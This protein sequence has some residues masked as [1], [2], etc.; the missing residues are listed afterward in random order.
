MGATAVAAQALTQQQISKVVKKYTNPI[1]PIT[2]KGHQ[3]FTIN[4]RNEGELKQLQNV[5][6]KYHLDEWTVPQIGK[7]D[8]RVPSEF[9]TG[10]Q[11][12]IQSPISVKIEDLQ[13]AI[14]ESQMVKESGKFTTQLSANPP[15]LEF[16][17]KYRTYEELTQLVKKLNQDYP[18]HTEV[19]SIGKTYEGRDQTGLR[20]KGKNPKYRFVY[21]GGQHAREWI[22]PATATYI[23]NALAGLYGKDDRITKVVDLF[24]IYAIPVL[25]ADG[26][27]YT[28]TKERMWR[29]N[30]QPN[31]GSNCVGT[32]NNRN[33]DAGWGGASNNPCDETYFGSKPF[34]A[35]ETKNIANFIKEKNATAYIDFHSYGQLVMY[36]FGPGCNGNTP[37][38]KKLEE[39]AKQTAKAIDVAPFKPTKMCSAGSKGIGMSIDWATG[40]GKVPYA[41]LIELEGNSFVLP[42]S[43]IIPSGESLLKAVLTMLEY[44]VQH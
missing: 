2:Y 43:K 15:N 13:Q 8:V 20:I 17:K 11:S 42:P 1:R 33:W 14:T 9:I 34:S 18:N 41:F 6:K 44:I 23:L 3:V 32:D 24:D 35:P 4:V 10:V 40:P 12:E 36:T 26:Y 5:I 19:F 38:A 7:V 21:H 27:H 30:R 16:F 29:K 39:C 31:T 22:S 37:T 28:F 25:N